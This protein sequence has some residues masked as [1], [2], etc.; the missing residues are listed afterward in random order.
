MTGRRRIVVIGGAVAS[1]LIAAA[2]LSHLSSGANSAAGRIWA[3]RSAG[4]PATTAPAPPSADGPLA[5]AATFATAAYTTTPLPALATPHLQLTLST[6]SG[7]A[8]NHRPAQADVVDNTLLDPRSASVLVQVD[9][10]RT[11]L[12]GPTP[13][14]DPNPHVLRLTMVRDPD[15]RWL[16]DDI[17]V[18]S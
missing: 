4:I 18:V 10:Q 12:D 6:I 14:P 15:G 1:V 2:L 11:W 7:L 16:V 17:D 9:V 3:R 13:A 8:P 5:V